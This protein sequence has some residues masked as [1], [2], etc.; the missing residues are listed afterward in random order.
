MKMISELLEKKIKIHYKKKKK[1]DAGTS[2]SPRGDFK[3][4]EENTH[5]IVKAK[6]PL[7]R[8]TKLP[9]W[10]NFS[11]KKNKECLFKSIITLNTDTK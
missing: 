10:S 9:W 7:V 8:R 11:C 1:I 6:I 2:K 3:W 5:V 4:L